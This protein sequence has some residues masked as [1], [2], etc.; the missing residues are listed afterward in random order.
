MKKKLNYIITEHILVVYK[1]PNAQDRS[2]FSWF[3]CILL[4]IYQQWRSF[5]RW[6]LVGETEYC[7]QHDLSHG[8]ILCLWGVHWLRIWLSLQSRNEGTRGIYVDAEPYL[9]HQVRRKLEWSFRFE[10]F[11]VCKLLSP[12]LVHH[13]F[14]RARPDKLN[15]LICVQLILFSH[16]FVDVAPRCPIPMLLMLAGLIDQMNHHLL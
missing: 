14:P 4:L 3:H 1:E 15:G 10:C 16:E 8:G 11:L 9:R 13:K 6:C 7:H 5:S 12:P 2:C